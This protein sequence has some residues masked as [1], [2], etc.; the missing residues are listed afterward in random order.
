MEDLV[1]DEVVKYLKH[2]D[3]IFNTKLESNFNIDELILFFKGFKNLI[4]EVTPTSE[5]LEIQEKKCEILDE[6]SLNDEQ[7]Q[8][9]NK[10]CELEHKTNEEYRK[11][12]LIL[13][14]IFMRCF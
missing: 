8:S 1:Q 5:Y 13:M 12:I 4:D 9:F 6:I 14:Y 2:F 7:V 3:K 10:Y 11:E